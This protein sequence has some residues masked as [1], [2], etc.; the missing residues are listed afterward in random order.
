MKPS[1]NMDDFL[2]ISEEVWPIQ[3]NHLFMARKSGCPSAADLTHFGVLVERE[4]LKR[5][6]LAQPASV[7]AGWKL[8]LA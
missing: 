5:A 4:A 6:S 7:P 8:V 1:M 2:T 3:K